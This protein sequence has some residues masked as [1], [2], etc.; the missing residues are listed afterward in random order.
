VLRVCALLPDVRVACRHARPPEQQELIQRGDRSDLL[1]AADAARARQ[2]PEL[3]ADLAA[4]CSPD[5]L[6]KLVGLAD[7]TTPM[8]V[9]KLGV[10]LDHV[11]SSTLATVPDGAV[12]KALAASLPEAVDVSDDKGCVAYGLSLNLTSGDPAAAASGAGEPA[13]VAICEKLLG[14]PAGAGILVP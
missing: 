8:M 9:G 7:E 14:E 3:A 13:K 5:K 11:T 12:A 10:T 4:A 2:E 1:K 6:S